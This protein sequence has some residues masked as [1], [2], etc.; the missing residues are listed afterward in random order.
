MV[1]HRFDLSLLAPSQA[2]RSLDPFASRMSIGEFD[3]LRLIVSELV[4]N[5][6]RHS[7]QGDG[8]EIEMRVEL[9]AGYVR[10][11]VIDGG[12]GFD[13]QAATGI[14]GHGLDIVGRLSRLWGTDSG[15]PSRVWAEVALHDQVGT[16]PRPTRA[17]R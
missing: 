4:T 1:R 12:P 5:A 8:A 16:E 10:I 2:R 14:R 15:A 6:V 9:H 3:D 17:L 13:E 7:G 11:E